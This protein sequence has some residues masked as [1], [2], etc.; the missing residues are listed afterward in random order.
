MQMSDDLLWLVV[1]KLNVQAVLDADF[2]LDRVTGV[3]VVWQRVDDDVLFFDEVAHPLHHR[4]SQ[5]ITAQQQA[6]HIIS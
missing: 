5:Q 6:Y 1:L 3:G 2:H 4:H